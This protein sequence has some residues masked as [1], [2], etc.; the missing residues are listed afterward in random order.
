MSLF[1][2]AAVVVA[3]VAAVVATA[4]GGATTPAP[5]PN[6][7]L[8]TVDTLRAD[9]MDAYGYDRGTAPVFARLAAAGVRFEH[10]L[11]QA[12]WTLPSMASVH[13]S[14]Y[15][16]QHGAVTAE[17]ALPAAA[18]T[19]AER[20]GALGYSTVAV[21]SHEF[22][23]AE[24][25]FA[26]GFDVFDESNVVG[27]EAVTSTDLTRTA[28][29]RLGGV[30]E[31]FFLWVH[32][33]DPHFAYVRHPRFGFA[34]GY[35]GGLPDQLTAGRLTQV[36][37]RSVDAADLAYINAVYD[38]EIAH[39]DEWVGKLWDGLE[40]RYGEGNNVLIFTADHGE[41]FLE[42]GRFFH[43]KDVYD[44]L[45]RVP[46][47]IAGAID[48]ELR[49]RVVAQTVEI[50]SIPKTVLGMLGAP[51]D[52]FGGVD[53][54]DIA[55]GGDN[56]PSFAEGSYAFGIDQR[57]RAVV[58]DGWKLIHRLDDDDYELYELASDPH[59]RNDRY[60]AEMDGV[61][62]ARLKELLAEFV[63]LPRLQPQ[64]VGLS[65]AEIERLRA[66]GYIR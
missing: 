28:L 17:T 39:T 40:T 61:V 33:F 10:A 36:E 30:S 21:V 38:E 16:S 62:V 20:L 2:A 64:P 37:R 42:R 49:G 24:H 50:R 12:P 26:Q 7:V 29:A 11:S 19:L 22:I 45:V 46:L 3:L 52:G 14:L 6:I 31:P 41:Y 65:P 25:G 56:E 59:E 23:T 1:R 66:L 27:H 63:D 54:L 13:T 18:E 60:G 57:K 58:R 44:S 43:G 32:Y 48:E 34:D 9:H 15:P 55:R 5:R 4:C 51:A 8:V 53:L 35:E 47:L